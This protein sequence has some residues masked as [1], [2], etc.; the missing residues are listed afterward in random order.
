MVVNEEET[1][2]ELINKYHK[3]GWL[4]YQWGV[5]VTSYA[6]LKL[7]EG[8]HSIPY[9]NFIYADTDSI[10]FVGEYGQEI[11]KLNEI[12]LDDEYSALDKKGKRHYIGIYEYEGKYSSFAT[13]GAK[14]YCYIKDKKLHVN[15][16]GVNKKAG[17]KELKAIKNFKEG[18][19]FKKAGGKMA[20]Y[21]DKP[22]P[23]HIKI[24]GHEV[25]IISNIALFDSTY[26]LGITADY[27][28]L[29]RILCNSDIK[30][31]LHYIR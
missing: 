25:D 26:T 11:E 2:E 9:P 29:I 16:S 13:L 12:Y 30:Y 19:I 24:D 22:I 23:D 27:E 28:R 7:E 1:L 3:S 4:P 15:I 20:V 6:R 5:W 31:S 14:K 17:A 8:I 21:N 10:K 18:F